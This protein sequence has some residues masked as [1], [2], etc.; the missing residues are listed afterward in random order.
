MDTVIA[1]CIRDLEVIKS[2]IGD[3]VSRNN[4]HLFPEFFGPHIRHIVEHYSAFFEATSAD[5]IICYDQR[6]RDSRIS[7][8]PE[9]AIAQI[10]QTIA[11][12]TALPAMVSDAGYGS[13]TVEFEIDPSNSQSEQMGSTVLRELLFLMHHTIHHCALL[14]LYFDQNGIPTPSNFG[15]APATLGYEQSNAR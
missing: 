8:N 15:K 2:L 12:L 14:R 11:R 7:D 3:A 9:N 10:E 4:G 13:V 1:A 6:C 5:D